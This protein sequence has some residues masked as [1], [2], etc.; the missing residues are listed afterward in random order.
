M[1]QIF[2]SLHT[3]WIGIL[4][5]ERHQHTGPRRGLQ[6][7]LEDAIVDTLSKPVPNIYVH[8][9]A[10][11]SGKTRAASNAAIRLHAEGRLVILRQGYDYTFKNDFRS[12]LRVCIG[13]PEDRS[14]D[15]IS[16][17]FPADRPTVLILDHADCL[18]KQYG[19]KDVVDTLDTLGIPVLILLGSWE[20]AVDLKKQGCLLL[21]EPGLGSWTQQELD[22]LYETFPERTKRRV[23]AT[24]P[25]LRERAR[26]A[27]SPGILVLESHEENKPNMLKTHRR[28]VA[29][30]D[31]REQRLPCRCRAPRN[32]ALR[33]ADAAPQ[34]CCRAAAIGGG[35][36]GSRRALRAAL[37]PAMAAAP[38]AGGRSAWQVCAAAAAAAAQEAPVAPT[39]RRGPCT[40]PRGP[41]EN[42]AGESRAALSREADPVFSCG[43]PPLPGCCCLHVRA[44]LPRRRMPSL[45][46]R[47]VG[48]S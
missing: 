35:T 44:R 26:L 3:T 6:H 16:T 37:P 48:L 46:V 42:P 23:E 36:G 33:A 5:A 10:Y 31:T 9:G 24:K 19:E 12:W 15:K 4:I 21:G 28:R 27:G 18:L 47:T 1:G 22:D 32:D 7:R 8:W 17:F 13:I 30:R 20:R 11:E 14:T 38:A 34:H 29:Q 40:W 43:L 2:T 45:L 25:E 39:A 41:G